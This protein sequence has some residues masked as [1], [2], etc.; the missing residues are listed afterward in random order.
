MKNEFYKPYKLLVLDIDS[1]LLDDNDMISQN[2]L[3]ALKAITE[4]GI[5][6]TLATGRFFNDASCFAKK[7]EISSP[8]IVLHGAQIKSVDGAI[9][10]EVALTPGVVVNLINIA[11]KMNLAFQAFQD[12]CLLIE[13]R[14]KWHNL[15][16]KHSYQSPEITYVNDITL[17]LK[18]KIIQFSFLGEKSVL[19]RLK[20]LIKK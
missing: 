11:R 1:T 5:A 18:N 12:N 17:Y 19:R 2:S 20:E 14:N 15:Y 3:E 8:M 9:L 7:L 6:I 10:K 16:I 4:K 13:K